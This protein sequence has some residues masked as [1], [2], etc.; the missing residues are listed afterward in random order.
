MFTSRADVL[1]DPKSDIVLVLGKVVTELKVGF[2][3]DKY[4]EVDVYAVNSAAE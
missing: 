2:F 3:S 1:E 4:G